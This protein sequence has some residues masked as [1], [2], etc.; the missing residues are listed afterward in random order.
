[1]VSL[2]V[3]ALL[4]IERQVIDAVTP[5]INYVPIEVDAMAQQVYQLKIN[6]S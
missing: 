2:N 6:T 4:I 1:M 5:T 3:S